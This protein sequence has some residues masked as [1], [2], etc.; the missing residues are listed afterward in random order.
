[1]NRMISEDSSGQFDTTIHM[2]YMATMTAYAKECCID[3]VVSAYCEDYS[4]QGFTAFSLAVKGAVAR[5]RFRHRT[6]N[7]TSSVL[8]L[9]NTKPKI[10]H[11]ISR[12]KEIIENSDLPSH[13]RDLLCERLE[14]FRRELNQPRLGFVKT[15]TVL[16]LVL[17]S[18]G[19]ATTV[20]AEGQTA[21]THIMRLIGLDR[22]TEEEEAQRLAPPIKALPPPAHHNPTKH[23]P[24]RQTSR[25][26][27]PPQGGDLDDEIPF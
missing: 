16:S 13:R 11:Y 27:A 12:L 15:L 21:V 10:E 14:E 17:A 23:H 6:V 24:T 25:Q 3:E 7:R 19:S 4:N 20:A 22:Q 5:I 2:Q 18:L 1:M 9:P 26:P 8:L